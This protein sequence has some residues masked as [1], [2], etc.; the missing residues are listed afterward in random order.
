MC[1]ATLLAGCGGPKVGA[2]TGKVDN[3]AGVDGGSSSCSAAAPSAATGCTYTQGYWKN[4]PDAWPVASLIIGGVTYKKDELLT[5]FGTSPGGDASLILAH[6]LIAAMLNVASGAVAPQP[7]SQAIADAQAWMTT[8]RPAGGR[9]PYGAAAGASTGG[10]AT[11]LTEALDG[12]N[13]G[14]AGVPHC[15]DGPKGG[16]AD[17]CTPS[18]STPPGS[19][20]PGSTPPGSTPPGSGNPPPPYMPPGFPPDGGTPIL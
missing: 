18:G 19:T 16:S 3:S 11:A 20:P 14:L 2:N 7:I 6:Q 15:G 13:S 17:A 9:L 5:L 10:D 12:F 8:N 1:V 4:H